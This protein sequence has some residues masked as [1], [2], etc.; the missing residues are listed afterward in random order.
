[1]NVNPN[2]NFEFRPAR[3]DEEFLEIGKLL[4]H[5]FANPDEPKDPRELGLTQEQVFCA[6]DGDHLASCSGAFDFRIAMNGKKMK[7]DGV[8]IVSTDPAYRRKGLVRNLMT[9]ILHASHRRDVPVAILWASM[10][11]IYQRFGYGYATNWNSYSIDPKEIAFESPIPDEGC[12]R[13]IVDREE[14]IKIASGLYA[15]HIA[16]HTLAI[17]RSP[18]F[19]SFFCLKRKR[20]DATSLSILTKRERPAVT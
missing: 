4:A 19:G 8:T 20:N 12:V 5:S 16:G 7:A 18:P 2:P 3:T 1:M 14:A 15:E 6:Y 17:H 11:A 9:Q 10:G 13:R